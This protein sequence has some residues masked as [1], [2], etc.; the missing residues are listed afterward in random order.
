MILTCR[1]SKRIKPRKVQQ[2]EIRI[3]FEFLQAE[4]V[5]NTRPLLQDENRWIS[6]FELIFGKQPFSFLNI[7][8]QTSPKRLLNQLRTTKERFE[9]LWK[10]QYVQMLSKRK[11][12]EPINLIEGQFVMI[13]EEFKKRENWP[14]GKIIKTYPGSDGVVRT[15]KVKFKDRELLRPVN[16][17]VQL[18]GDVEPI[19]NNKFVQGIT[20]IIALVEKRSTP[21]VQNASS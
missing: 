7:N 18:E 4:Y 11:F 19:S 10:S 8:I 14:I 17:L 21:S 2:I 15:V 16:G 20:F 1:I 13:P 5:I 6:P 9:T 3:P 12:K